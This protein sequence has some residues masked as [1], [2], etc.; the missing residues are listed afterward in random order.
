MD[1]I[2]KGNK[3][4]NVDG[5]KVLEFESVF[6]DIEYEDNHLC[7]NVA[8]WRDGKIDESTEEFYD[9]EIIALNEYEINK[10]ND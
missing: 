9:S 4:I 3:D 8:Y 10:E 2:I 5:W 6:Y 1:K 7:Y